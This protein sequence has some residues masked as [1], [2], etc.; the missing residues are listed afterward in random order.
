MHE[1]TLFHLVVEKPPAERAAFLDEACAGD[2]ALRRRLEV[3]LHEHDNPT[4]FLDRPPPGTRVRYLGDYELQEE[5]ARG[6]MGVVYKARQVSLNRWVALK[7]ILAGQL[8]SPADVQRFHREA[9]AAANLD[10]PN[11]VPIY[12]VGE[13]EGQHYFSMKLIEGTSLAQRAACFT[14]DSKA[15]ARLVTKVARA[16]HAAHQH[17]VL[18]RDLKPTN[19]LLDTAGEPYVVDF[20]LAKAMN[21]QGQQTQSGVVVGTPSYMAPEQA[22]SERA[23]TVAVDVYGLGAILYELLTGRP[24]FRAETQLDTILQ[25][26]ER[27][28]RR[29]ATLNHAI[30]RDL[31]TIC[32]KCLEKEPRRRYGSA[33][34]LAEDLERWLAGEPIQARASG[35]V[36]KAFKWVKR[37]KL[38]TLL[39]VVLVCWYF[40]V[41]LQWAWLDW[42]VLGFLMLAGLLRAGTLCRWALGT[43]SAISPN[44]Y[45]DGF[46]LPGSIVALLVLCFYPAE[47]AEKTSL[48]K[49]VLMI[50]VTWGLVLQWLRKRAQAGPLVLAVRTFLPFA[51][52]VGGFLAIMVVAEV[53]KLAEISEQTGGVLVAIVAQIEGVS[54]PIFLFAMLTVGL[55]IREHACVTFFRVLRWEELESYG[56]I[57]ARDLWVL[58]LKPRSNPIAIAKAVSPSRKD[59]VDRV[60]NTRLPRHDPAAAAGAAPPGLLA[61]RHEPA[62]RVRDVAHLMYIT[63]CMS[64]IAP[65]ALGIGF[66]PALRILRETSPIAVVVLLALGALS[67]SIGL[68]VT[69]GALKLRRLKSY[70]FG[71]ATVILATLPLSAGFVMGLP[72]GIWALLVLR[73]PDVQAAFDL[74]NNAQTSEPQS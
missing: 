30:D 46:L 69:A 19:I 72:F 23:L 17:G 10:H 58:Q 34:A 52:V 73:R 37:N 26:L 61:G 16:V 64:I 49:S 66:L 70:R 31:E 38:V 12:E 5:I 45:E 6:G 4:A 7:M 54:I 9:E 18:H 48:A 56:W 60:L 36:Q 33:L 13:H 21:G 22:R 74:A 59:T 47:L 39:F 1:E 71:R 68:I 35:S 42:A 67:M 8:A 41:R 57:P 44:L 25:V 53:S 43:V 3:L 40:N 14:A 63:G 50:A 51:L 32:L 15:A 20:G 55:E 27:D 65:I 24:P 62:G 29:P 28:P 11:I 2:P